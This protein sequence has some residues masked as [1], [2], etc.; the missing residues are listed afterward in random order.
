IVR[1]ESG[2]VAHLDCEMLHDVR[3]IRPTPQPLDEPARM[4]FRA[5]VLGESGQAAQQTLG[6]SGDLRAIALAELLTDVELGDEHSLI[7]KDIGPWDETG[8]EDKHVFSVAAFLA[9]RLPF[10]SLGE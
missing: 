3:G 4:P 2:L 7:V 10:T 5:S 1:A 9:G 8:V 6:Q